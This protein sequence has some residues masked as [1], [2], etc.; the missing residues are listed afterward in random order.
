MRKD[1]YL[2]A[3]ERLL[4]EMRVQVRLKNRRGIERTGKRL[5]RIRVSYRR[6]YAA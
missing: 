2:K 6:R 3:H 1:I 5:H 4:G